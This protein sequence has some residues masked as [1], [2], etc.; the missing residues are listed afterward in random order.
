M[1][2]KANSADTLQAV[3]P[4]AYALKVEIDGGLV[5]VL[6]R[7]HGDERLAV[8]AAIDLAFANRNAVLACLKTTSMAL[9]Q[10][11]DKG[12]SLDNGMA[13]MLLERISTVLKLSHYEKR[14]S[15]SG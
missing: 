14:T 13:C 1:D 3:T 10:C 12:I 4:T 15:N 8:L 9:S 7:L 6:A 11:A 5:P 2:S